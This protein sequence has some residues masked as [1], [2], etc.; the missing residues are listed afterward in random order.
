[1]EAARPRMALEVGLDRPAAQGDRPLGDGPGRGLAEETA[2]A[3]LKGGVGQSAR[4][5]SG[6][7]MRGGGEGRVVVSAGTWC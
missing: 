7:R 6:K 5:P 4:A 1:M 3:G 2:K